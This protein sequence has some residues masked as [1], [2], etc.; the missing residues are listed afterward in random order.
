G[1]TEPEVPPGDDASEAPTTWE[2]N[3]EHVAT[4]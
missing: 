3:G 2:F 1:V 4:V